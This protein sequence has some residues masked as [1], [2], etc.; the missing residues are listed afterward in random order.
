MVDENNS[1]NK[2][3]MM[4]IENIVIGTPIDNPEELLSSSIS[5][6]ICNEK[7]KTLFTQETFLPRI[8]VDLGIYKSINEI[9]RN[10]PELV[11]NLTQPDYFDS[12]KVAKKR[13]LWIVV[14]RTH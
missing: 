12:L 5:D 8:L 13:W 6:W 4:Y 2:E 7:A 11:L 14:G 3:K 1:E 10:K 9:R